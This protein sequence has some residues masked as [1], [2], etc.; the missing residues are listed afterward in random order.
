MTRPVIPILLWLLALAGLGGLYLLDRQARRATAE[1]LSG[2]IAESI[3]AIEKS[4]GLEA[5]RSRALLGGLR[6]QLDGLSSELR[7]GGSPT[8]VQ[9]AQAPETPGPGRDDEP[10][11]AD[12]SLEALPPLPENVDPEVLV[13]SLKLHEFFGDPKFNPGGRELDRL[14]QQRAIN[15]VDRARAMAGIID[16]DI[17][18][19][20]LE[21]MQ[22][23]AQTGDYVDYAKGERR[24]PVKGVITTAEPLP[25]GGIRMFYCFPEEHPALYDLKRRSR[26]ISETAVR[27]LLALANGTPIEG[28]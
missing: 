2:R 25:G 7:R 18:L 11:L 22:R 23:M 21:A 19:S 9:D 8:S 28:E 1:A 27:Q 17:K 12:V 13:R 5:A 10:P 26:Q 20:L 14:E 24:Q 15:V 3:G 16:S 4:I 6:S